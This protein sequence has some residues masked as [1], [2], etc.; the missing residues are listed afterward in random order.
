MHRCPPA[1]SR[2]R[3]E[4]RC[5]HVP[6]APPAYR[7]SFSMKPVHTLLIATCIAALTT[8]ARAEAKADSPPATEMDAVHVNASTL[9]GLADTDALTTVDRDLLA[10]LQGTTAVDAFNY[11]AGV[12]GINE[13]GR[14]SFRLNIRGLEGSG[15]VAIDIDGAQQNLIDH[16]HGAS[17]NRLW[18]D[19]SLLKSVDV[20]RG[21]ASN[22]RGGGALAG[23]VSFQTVDP[24]DLLA[25]DARFGG[26]ANAGYETNG[27]GRTGTLAAATRLNDQ[28]SILAAMSA[29]TFD[30]YEAAD[31]T[32]VEASGS[33]NHSL[34]FKTMFTPSDLST[35]RFSYQAARN[36]YEGSG[37]YARGQLRSPFIR[38]EAVNIDTFTAGYDLRGAT[39]D[40]LD[41]HASAYHTSTARDE[42]RL[43]TGAS[44]FHD[45]VTRGIN[46]HNTSVLRTAATTH[47]FTVGADWFEDELVSLTDGANAARDP[48]GFRRQT[49]LFLNGTHDLAPGLTLFE[50]LRHDDFTM[51]DLGA[52]RLHGDNLSGR[53]G[54]EFQPF[55]ASDA[56]ADFT[57]FTSWGTGF[58]TPT[59]AEAFVTSEPS[60]GRNGFSPGTLAN[61]NLAP[62]TSG[63]WEIGLQR[64]RRGL[65]TARDQARLRV[66]YYRQDL[67]DIIGTTASP[68][69][70]YN[71]LAN[72]GDDRLAGLEIEARYDQGGWFLGGTFDRSERDLVG[73]GLPGDPIQNQPWSAFVFG[74]LRLLDRNLTLGAEVRRVGPFE[75]TDQTNPIVIERLTRDAFTTVNLYAHY[76]ATSSLSLRARVDNVFDE[77][78]Q[79]YQTLDPAAGLNSRFSIEYQF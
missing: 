41:L 33:E 45:I 31:G 78:Y 66:A 58:R 23:S 62:E 53:A 17:T 25:P 7:S 56:W 29:R 22:K 24:V 57:V 68:D 48:G 28:W 30:D 3:T 20:V 42:T 5:I 4:L 71:L 18:L 64:T 21:P 72:L 27:H 6:A 1:T 67:R 39:G 8:Q 38:A 19:S 9:I 63:T 2:R 37:A 59:L 70:D 54:V 76:R 14:Q 51:G 16:N 50:G 52:T 74:G 26:F 13:G 61:P 43:D 60:S 32:A 35:L 55:A 49:G 12:T 34:L 73:S 11:V 77:V 36:D 79:A 46:V 47:T 75:Q 15:R 10:N 69:P 65:F 40:W 44:T